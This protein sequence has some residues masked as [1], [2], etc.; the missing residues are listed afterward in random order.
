MAQAL[1]EAGAWSKIEQVTGFV[2]VGAGMDDVTDTGGFV[3]ATVFTTFGRDV[4]AL[5]SYEGV[6][7]DGDLDHAVYARRI[8][9]DGT[10]VGGPILLKA[11]MGFFTGVR[12]LRFEIPPLAIP[13]NLLTQER[14]RLDTLVGI[15]YYGPSQL[16]VALEVVN[17][18]LFDHPGGP[19]NRIELTPQDSFET[20]LRITRPFFR[21]RLDVTLLG[22]VAGE[23]FQDGGLFRASAEYE[24]TDSIKLEGGW[25]V[26][27]GGPRIGLGAFDS[28]DRLYAEAKYSF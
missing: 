20:A 26:F 16:T 1:T 14:E 18:H 10:I 7:S 19:P 28:N 13:G 15:E 3:Q 8:E 11:E 2:D 4:F 6:S 25:L 22:L 27:F 23:R 24:L 5:V 9:G 12:T 17:R 21:E